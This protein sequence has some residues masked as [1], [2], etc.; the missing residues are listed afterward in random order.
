MLRLQITKAGG[1]GGG[2]NATTNVTQTVNVYPP[3]A[4]QPANDKKDKK[5]ETDLPAKV[6]YSISITPETVPD[7]ETGALYLHYNQNWFYEEEVKMT[8]NDKGLLSNAETTSTDKTAQV[9]YNLADT[10]ANVFKFASTGG[11][12][13]AAFVEG[14]PKAKSKSRMRRVAYKDLNVDIRF[15][16]F[17]DRD[18]RR[19][20][21]LFSDD[22]TSDA[23]YVCPFYVRVNTPQQSGIHV[24][25][26]KPDSRKGL[27]FREPVALQVE[28]VGREEKFL[29]E[30]GRSLR[31]AQGVTG[32]VK[33]SVK[34]RQAVANKAYER[35]LEEYQKAMA[36]WDKK[37]QAERTGVA[38]TKPTKPEDVASPEERTVLDADATL[39]KQ[40]DRA[41]S[42]V[43]HHTERVTVMANNK[44]RV[45]AYNVARSAFVSNKKQD[46]TIVDGSLR[47]VHLVKPSEA[48]GFT[49]IPLT[50]SNKLLALP[51]DILTLRQDIT[52][53][54]GE[55]LTQKSNAFNTQTSLDN[56][57]ANRALSEETAR[58]QAEKA[59]L[60]AELELL[61]MQKEGLPAEKEEKK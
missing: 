44:Q 60:Q 48:V 34:A 33:D 56:A 12:G 59:R 16:P 10:A 50:L 23:Y 20:A 54:Q 35:E 25:A 46:L 11:L 27:Y 57:V 52:T 24:P 55:I 26:K 21:S 38:P 41:R 1:G 4:A 14:A 49:E 61:K 31:M 28:V 2:G 13:A 6:A 9:I 32:T 53:K 30:V 15:D 43:D 18:L 5:D 58:L 29:E 51:K 19:L 39:K 47:G 42:T 22:E 3:G 17:S 7:H 45:F 40:Y 37:P 8:V 36:E